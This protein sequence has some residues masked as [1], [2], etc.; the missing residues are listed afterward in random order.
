MAYIMDR[1]A[2]LLRIISDDQQG[3][4]LET[5]I[6]QMQHLC[7][8]KLENNGIKR[9]FPPENEACRKQDDCIDGENDIP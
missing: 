3:I 6:K 5:F 8:N 2:D 1:G 4:L 9:L 7:G